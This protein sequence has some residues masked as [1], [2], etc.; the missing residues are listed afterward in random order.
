MGSGRKDT[1]ESRYPR[2]NLAKYKLKEPYHF[3]VGAP[4]FEESGN[5]RVG[6]DEVETWAELY[7]I[8]T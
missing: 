6:R 4:L 8:P 2:Q 7:N 5:W 1:L 3:M